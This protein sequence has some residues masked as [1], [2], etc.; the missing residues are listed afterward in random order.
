[1]S[2]KTSVTRTLDSAATVACRSAVLS[3]FAAGRFACVAESRLKRHVRTH[4]T[5]WWTGVP[6][7]VA[8]TQHALDDAAEWAAAA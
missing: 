5:S 7:R 4:T 8:E 6:V 2:V 3:L 1:M